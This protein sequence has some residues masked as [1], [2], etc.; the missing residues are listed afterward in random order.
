MARD[1]ETNKAREDG[2]VPAPLMEHGVKM[3]RGEGH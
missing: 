1:T 2:D 3:A